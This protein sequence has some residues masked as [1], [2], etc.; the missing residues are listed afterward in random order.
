MEIETRKKMQVELE[1]WKDQLED[2]VK[3]NELKVQKKLRES[4]SADIKQAQARLLKEERE[5]ADLKKK[6]A[7][8]EEAEK[9]YVIDEQNRTNH[10]NAITAKHNELVELN[11][12]LT[13]EALDLKNTVD[14]DS[15]EE[16]N[17]KFQV[18]LFRFNE[19]YRL[20]MRRRL[21]PS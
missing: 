21:R 17:L 20:K 10:L 13:Q 11:K 8:V 18:I 6:Y 2:T 15:A 7:A 14:N 5:L 9:N 3:N 1:K 12:A 16:T 4:E 19:M